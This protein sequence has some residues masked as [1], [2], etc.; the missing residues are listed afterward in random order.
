MCQLY[1]A[2]SNKVG[3]DLCEQYKSLLDEIDEM[4]RVWIINKSNSRLWE[5]AIDEGRV[6]NPSNEKPINNGS[7]VKQIIVVSKVGEEETQVLYGSTD[8][9]I[10]G[11]VEKT[12]Q[13]LTTV[14][15]RH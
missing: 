3:Y 15:P 4:V 5:L 11:F 8:N 14:Y 9:D 1:I 6:I 12:L 13:N 2:E 7:D 10:N